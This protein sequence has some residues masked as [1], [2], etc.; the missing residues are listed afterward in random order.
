MLWTTATWGL[1][2]RLE[3][4]YIVMY[5]VTADAG[6]CWMYVE[7]CFVFHIEN[8]LLF[9]ASAETE[10]WNNIFEVN[11]LWKL[12]YLRGHTTSEIH[13]LRNVFCALYFTNNFVL[14]NQ[15]PI[16]LSFISWKLQHYTLLFVLLELFIIKRLSYTFMPCTVLRT[17]SKDRCYY[18]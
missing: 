11:F 10:T 5:S 8:V 15:W 6:L 3:L 16:S 14:I 7:V 18:M 17:F 1:R 4:W 9:L 12:K 13:L 2:K